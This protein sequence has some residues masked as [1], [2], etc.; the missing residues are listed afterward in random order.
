[1]ILTLSLSGNAL[2]E[3]L[4]LGELSS[5]LDREFANDK[6]MNDSNAVSSSYGK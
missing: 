5:S 6:D 2:D 1:M 3:D 4:N